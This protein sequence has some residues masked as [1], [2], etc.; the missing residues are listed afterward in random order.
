MMRSAIVMTNSHVLN[1]LFIH[2]LPT[3]HSLRL[4]LVEEEVFSRKMISEISITFKIFPKN[5]FLPTKLSLKG[6]WWSLK[7]KF[8]RSLSL[9]SPSAYYLSLSSREVI[10]WGGLI[11]CSLETPPP[12]T[13]THVDLR[14]G[15]GRSICG[16]TTDKTCL[17]RRCPLWEEIIFML[18]C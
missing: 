14:A 7:I 13:T 12:P 11:R 6:T 2:S 8:D 3:T 10:H 9:K 16:L 17:R 5:V 4:S 18:C 15:L 1:L